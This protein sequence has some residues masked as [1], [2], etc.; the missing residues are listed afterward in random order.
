MQITRAQ[1][2][3]ASATNTMCQME[4]RDRKST[5]LGRRLFET[6]YADIQMDALVSRNLDS[7][8]EVCKRMCQ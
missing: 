5:N 6:S 2:D 8:L 7:G 3:N 1:V 4:W